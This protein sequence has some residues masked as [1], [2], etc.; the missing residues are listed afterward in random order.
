VNTD[1]AKVEA[2]A[3]V[4]LIPLLGLVAT[5]VILTGR[6][7]PAGWWRS[8]NAPKSP[9][10]NYVEM[11]QAFGQKRYDDA[12]AAARRV[13]AKNPNREGALRTEAACLVRLGRFAEA[14]IA[15]AALLKNNPD[16]I[17]VRL[18]QAAAWNGLGRGFE[19]AQAVQQ[20]R[21]HPRA[22]DQQRE[23]ARRILDALDQNPPPPVQ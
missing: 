5:G 1:A 20:I 22:T 11:Q 6:A 2:L 17:P 4:A 8:R 7:D 23:L 19:A 10:E 3:Y 15:C 9:V 18:T 16:D 12:L 14:D 13:L 21:T